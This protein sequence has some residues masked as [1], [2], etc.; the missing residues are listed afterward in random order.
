MIPSRGAKGPDGNDRG[1]A[2]IESVKLA[3]KKIGI[4]F[5][6]IDGI[7]SIKCRDKD[8]FRLTGKILANASRFIKT[9]ID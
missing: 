7:V 2:V 6:D 8:S 5:G 3:S 4:N 1:D 9:M